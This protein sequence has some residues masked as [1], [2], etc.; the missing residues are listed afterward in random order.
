MDCFGLSQQDYETFRDKLNLKVGGQR[1]PLMASIEVTMG[2]N[3]R[4]KHCYIPFSQRAGTCEQELTLPEFER[5][6][7][8]IA[9]EGCLWL[10]LTGGEPFSR[11]DFLQI[12]DAAKRRGFI[13]SVYTNGTLLTEEIADHL[14]EW[15]PFVVE[16]SLY[17]ATQETYER[18][19]GIPGSYARCMQ[20]IALLK[21]RGIPVNLKSVVLTINRHELEQMQALSAKLGCEFR[22]DPNINAG[23]QGDLYPTRLRLTP[24]EIVAL[25]AADPKHAAAWRE[26]FDRNLHI[27]FD[28]KKMY[29]CG[30]GLG[31]F[32]IDGYGRMSMCMSARYPYYDLRKDSFKKGWDEFFPS[33]RAMEYADD[34]ECKDCPLR[35][36]CAQCPGNAMCEMGKPDVRVPF[37]CALT[38]R[39]YQEFNNG[40]LPVV[41][42]KVEIKE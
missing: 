17:G 26:T 3:L 9:A 29:N 31:G 6:F 37:L 24:E 19:T 11:P 2:C 20:G 27:E 15:R 30:A 34:F 41:R 7:D 22:Y 10:L 35:L 5:I 36:A 8:E 23:I 4:C 28:R 33:I 21:S 1:V 42:E 13:L 32:H 14:A 18:V 16:I 25:E 40:Q 38:H 12:Y 39:R